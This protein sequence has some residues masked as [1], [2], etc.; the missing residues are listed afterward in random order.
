[1]NFD[2]KDIDRFCMF[3]LQEW[4]YVENY[5][6]FGFFRSDDMTCIHFLDYGW[7]KFD[8]TF[9][10]SSYKKY[11]NNGITFIEFDFKPR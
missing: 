7:K 10:I 6:Y 11:S 2:L 1:M 5:S 9:D 8:V 3:K 4:G